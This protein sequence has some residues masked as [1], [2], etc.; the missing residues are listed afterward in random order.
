[1][2]VQWEICL[3]IQLLDYIIYIFSTMSCSGSSAMVTWCVEILKWLWSPPD[4]QGTSPRIEEQCDIK[5]ISVM[6][7][8]R[9]KF[10]LSCAMSGQLVTWKHNDYKAVLQKRDSQKRWAIISEVRWA[11]PLLL[12]HTKLFGEPE[13]ALPAAEAITHEWHLRSPDDVYVAR[14]E[15]LIVRSWEISTGLQFL[16]PCTTRY[17]TLCEVLFLASLQRLRMYD[18]WVF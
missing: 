2:E 10:C 18:L 4:Q 1:M 7:F 16:D 11:D 6:S 5:V 12:H 13:A 17:V 3:L 9:N 15:N 8:F 14:E